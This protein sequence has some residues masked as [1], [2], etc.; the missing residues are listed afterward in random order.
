MLEA[1]PHHHRATGMSIIYS[2]GV[3]IFGGFSPFI[4]TWLIGATGNPM[5]PAWY[6]LA[7][8]CISLFALTRFPNK[9]EAL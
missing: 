7:A 3:T 8:L 9:R 1:F 2:F 5:A 4:V 6:L